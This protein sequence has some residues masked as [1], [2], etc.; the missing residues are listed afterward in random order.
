M[1][2]FLLTPLDFNDVI[3]GGKKFLHI[4]RQGQFSKSPVLVGIVIWVRRIQL[5]KH[6]SQIPT[7]DG[8]I[9]PD[10]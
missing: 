1:T 9:L 6:L 4:F 10:L 3:I 7:E 5:K 2:P 8:E